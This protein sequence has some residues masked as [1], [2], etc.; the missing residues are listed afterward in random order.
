M[1]KS[2]LIGSVCN[3]KI[4]DKA[5]LK[6]VITERDILQ[7]ANLTKDFNPIHIDD[8]FAATTRFKGRIAHGELIT[9]I[10]SALIGTVLPGPGSIFLE[11]KV[12]FLKPAR[13]NDTIT[14]AAEIISIAERKPILV[15]KVV[16]VNQYDQIILEGEYTV[17]KEN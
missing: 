9:G 7:I 6:K 4:G 8:E 11:Q 1:S 15:L 14:A 17:L 12:R 3:L 2:N 13:P 16:C 10:I 5:S